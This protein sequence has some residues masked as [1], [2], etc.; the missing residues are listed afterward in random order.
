MCI[1]VTGASGQLGHDVCKALGDAAVGISSKD[2][3]ITDEK[4]ITEYIKKLGPEAIIHCAAYT[5]VDKAEGEKERCFAA[6]THAT[7]YIAKAAAEI[8]AKLM[9]ISTDYV[10]EG[11]LDRP[12]ETSDLPNPIN[13]YGASKLAGENAV[14]EALEKHFIIRTSWVFGENGHNFV[15]TMLRLGKT[16]KELRVV[17][18]QFGSPT[19]TRDLAALLAQMIRTE[20]YGLYHATN[21]GFCS[22]FEFACT[23]FQESGIDVNVLPVASESYPT[24]AK[25]PQN[26]R[27]SKSS[28]DMAGFDRL[29]SWEKATAHFIK[30]GS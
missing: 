22:W 9:Y 18:D 13:V 28:L 10:F 29:E 25:R 1:L 5:A 2:T 27:L 14:K 8:G 30:R 20:K 24:A 12:Y 7:G 4:K 11:K 16:N 3:D 15:K 23:I 21:E 19:Y 6:N 17:N 26:S